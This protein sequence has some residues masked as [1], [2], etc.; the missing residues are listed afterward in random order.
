MSD[1]K[2]QEAHN[3]VDSLIVINQFK[4]IM[5]LSSSTATSTTPASSANS[6]TCTPGITEKA[7]INA[8]HES[9]TDVFKD[10][11]SSTWVDGMASVA[12][13]TAIAGPTSTEESKQMWETVSNII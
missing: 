3:S 5:S 12:V 7:I 1:G 11:W 2:K 10:K 6:S 8:H 4:F 9:D 13:Y